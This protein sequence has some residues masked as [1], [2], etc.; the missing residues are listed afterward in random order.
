VGIIS[1]RNI[2]TTSAINLEYLDSLISTFLYANTLSVICSCIC[3]KRYSPNIYSI[4]SFI[5]LN[6]S[7]ILSLRLYVKTKQLVI[8]SFVD[9]VYKKKKEKKL[10]FYIWTTEPI[11]INFNIYI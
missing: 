10:L 3:G 6:K 8:S 11:L 7:T 1:G 9:I 5:L 4:L 2:R